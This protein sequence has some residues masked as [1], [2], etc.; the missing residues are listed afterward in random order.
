[1]FLN[2]KTTFV[3]LQKYLYKCKFFL[4][5]KFKIIDPHS[6]VIIKNEIALV[7][8]FIQVKIVPKGEIF[9]FY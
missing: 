6:R 1:M 2:Y 4:P 7:R 5:G 3:N 9:A 8:L